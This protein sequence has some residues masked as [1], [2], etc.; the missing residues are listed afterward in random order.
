MLIDE[1]ERLRHAFDLV[2]V[3]QP[4][5]TIAY[6]VLPDHLHAIWRLPEGDA[7]FGTRWSAIK[8]AFSASLAPGT[9]RSTSKVA[10]RE[11]G[12]WQ[13]RFWEHQIRDDTDLQRH[14]DYIH[15]NPVKHGHAARVSNWRP[16]SFHEYVKR[17]WLPSDWAGAD[18]DDEE[19]AKGERR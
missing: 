17:G 18:V 14:V 15:F 12:V 5:K 8:R 7:D 3:R 2:R 10:K 16:S 1:I 4:F 19:I 9:D 11:K 6:C 13:R